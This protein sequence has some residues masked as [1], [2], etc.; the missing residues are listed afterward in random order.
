M[1]LW[2]V[3]K[4][5]RVDFILAQ[6]V[7]AETKEQAIEYAEEIGDW[8]WQDADDEYSAEVSK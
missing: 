1:K 6:N 5:S 3:W 2:T 7:E 4:S 8:E